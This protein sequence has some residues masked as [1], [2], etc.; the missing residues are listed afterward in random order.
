MRFN[1]FEKNTL[2]KKI[3][4]G[5]AHFLYVIDKTKDGLHGFYL[6]IDKDGMEEYNYISKQDINEEF[7]R[8]EKSNNY[9]EVLVYIFKGL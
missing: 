7:I 6:F 2:Y 1:D 8:L 9:K 4:P 3:Y 5:E